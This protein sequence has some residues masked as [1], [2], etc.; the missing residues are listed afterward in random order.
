VATSPPTSSEQSPPPPPPSSLPR[1]ISRVVLGGFLLFAGIGHLTRQR[2]EFQ[3][4]VPDWVPLDPDFV[5]VAS[6]VVEIAL[7]L[8]L[9][10]LPRY[11]VPIGWTVAA[12]F[13]VIFP[14]NISQYVTGT[15]AFG[16]DSDQSR[17]IRLFFQPVL[18]AW[19]LWSTGAWAAWRASRRTA[20]D[21]P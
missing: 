8:A 11:R 2:E 19:A 14:G 10:A 21:P 5:V 4:Q 18:V 17:L 3:A 16:L 9:I 15:D 13:V 6:G 12:F 1:T 7:G 20:V